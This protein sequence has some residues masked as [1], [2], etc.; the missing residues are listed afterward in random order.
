M[1]RWD[2]TGW[3][4]TAAPKPTAVPAA[5]APTPVPAAPSLGAY[6]G[7]ASSQGDLGANFQI[8][9]P[10]AVQSPWLAQM[11]RQADAQKTQQLND[12]NAQSAS[13][14]AAAQANLA[15]HGGLSGGAAERMLENSSNNAA[16]AAQGVRGAADQARNQMQIGDMQNERQYQ[17]GLQQSNIQTRLQDLQNRQN[18]D[19]TKYQEQMKA[20]GADQTAKATEAA[21]FMPG[22]KIDMADG[23]VKNIEDIMPGD[24]LFMGG[25]VIA[26]IKSIPHKD[27]VVYDHC[28]VFV[29]GEHFVKEAG[30]WVKVKSSPLSKPTH[31]RPRVVYNLVTQKFRIVAN[32]I[33]FW[34]WDDTMLKVQSYKEHAHESHGNAR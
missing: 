15:R 7:A 23:T 1:G 10:G 33:E 16:L 13:N 4:T 19:L 14:A 32:K 20:Y 25:A 24:V 31:Y 29:T 21:C 12:V 11:L 28:G 9:D 30:A 27:D 2:S 3:G 6:R 34:D 5:P 18:Y 22:T 26:T 17:T 8:K